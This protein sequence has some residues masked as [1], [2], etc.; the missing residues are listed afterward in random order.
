VAHRLTEESL[1]HAQK[2]VV[3]ATL[4]IAAKLP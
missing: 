1:E 3:S 4:E 2:Q